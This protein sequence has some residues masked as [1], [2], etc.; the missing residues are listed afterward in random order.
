MDA[1]CRRTPLVSRHLFMLPDTYKQGATK[2]RNGTECTGM[3][4]NVLK[5]AGMTRN[6]YRNERE[7]HQN[8]IHSGKTEWSS[9]DG[10][11][12]AKGNPNFFTLPPHPPPPH[13]HLP[14]E[15]W[16]SW[17]VQSKLGKLKREREKKKQSK[18]KIKIKKHLGWLGRGLSWITPHLHCSRVW[19]SQSWSVNCAFNAAE[20]QDY[21]WWCNA[22]RT[23]HA[24]ANY[25]L[26]GMDSLD[27]IL[28][29]VLIICL[30]C[31]I[32][33]ALL[34]FSLPRVH[35]SKKENLK[36]NDEKVKKLGRNDFPVVKTMHFSK[37]SIVWNS[38]NNATSQSKII[39]N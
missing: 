31:L 37:R 19:N 29:C 24:C 4:R 33:R 34:V 21:I 9:L 26:I 18:T 13:P 7:W 20:I 11:A 10:W 36:N 6:Q 30:F 5:R 39:T 35:L 3:T 2:H 8:V 32:F 15:I 28:H 23:Y 17:E 38:N 27:W 25:K 22:V 16:K 12:I 1:F 14:S